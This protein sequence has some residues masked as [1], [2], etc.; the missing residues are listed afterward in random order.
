MLREDGIVL[1]DGTAS[2]LAEH[3]FLITTTTANAAAVLAHMEFY[4]QTV[5]P[6]LDVQFCS[7]T[8]QWAGIALA[9]PRARD[10]LARVVD[11][12]NVGNAALPYMAVAETTLRGVEARIFRISFSGELAYEINVPSGYGLPVWELLMAVGADFGGFTMCT[13]PVVPT[14]LNAA[15]AAVIDLMPGVVYLPPAFLTAITWMWFVTA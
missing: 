5:W 12:L 8:E 11:G 15:E 9:G 4:A 1:D 10:V 2:R 13:S 3:H 6:E 14:F 7:V